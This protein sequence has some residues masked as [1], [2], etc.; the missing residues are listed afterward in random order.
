[1]TENM[2]LISEENKIIETGNG[3]FMLFHETRTQRLEC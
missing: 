3:M 2:A 1:M